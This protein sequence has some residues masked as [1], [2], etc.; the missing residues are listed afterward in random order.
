MLALRSFSVAHDGTLAPREG[1][2]PPALRFAWRGRPCE[3]RLERE[4][5]RLSAM[6]GRIPSTAEPGADRSWTLEEVRRLPPEMPPGWA[7]RVTPDHRLRLETE[8]EPRDTAPG[9]LSEM[10]RFALS[11]DPYL[12][13]LESAGVGKAKT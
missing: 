4:R 9:L 5:L 2:G 13:R 6:A 11:L 7:L 3:A 1:H 8:A 12:E 10:V